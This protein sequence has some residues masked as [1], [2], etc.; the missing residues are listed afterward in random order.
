MIFVLKISSSKNIRFPSPKDRIETVPILWQ[1]VAKNKKQRVN[2]EYHDESTIQVATLNAALS[3]NALYSGS[4][5]IGGQAFRDENDALSHRRVGSPRDQGIISR[6]NGEEAGKLV[7]NHILGF[8]EKTSPIS[9]FLPV[10][11]AAY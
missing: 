4:I 3:S 7:I 5:C 6:H 9:S 8:P 10:Q 1:V 2:Q 11:P